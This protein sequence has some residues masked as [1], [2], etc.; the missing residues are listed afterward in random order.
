MSPTI[1][2]VLGSV[3]RRTKPVKRDKYLRGRVIGALGDRIMT[4]D[5]IRNSLTEFGL[6]T[7]RLPATHRTVSAYK[8]K[9]YI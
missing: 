5:H 7:P 9:T 4:S 1:L 2:S 6:T 3:H 8:E